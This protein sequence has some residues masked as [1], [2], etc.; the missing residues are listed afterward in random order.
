MKLWHHTFAAQAI[1]RDG[2]R[3]GKG[4]Y[5][6]VDRWYGVWV[7]AEPLDENEG[8]TGDTYLTVEV[9]EEIVAPYE[10]IEEGKG[11]REFLIPAEVL[12]Q[13]GPPKVEDRVA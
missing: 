8:A 12:N 1:L 11:Y 9:P 10:W 3:D 7:S 2:F 6:T 4:T 5:L 13:Y